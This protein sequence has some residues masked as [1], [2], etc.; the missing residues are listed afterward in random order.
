MNELLDTVELVVDARKARL[1]ALDD[2][3][4]K[5]DDMTRHLN[6]VNNALQGLAQPVVF[7]KTAADIKAMI[8]QA[9]R[10]GRF[11]KGKAA[12]LNPKEMAAALGYDP[13]AVESFITQSMLGGRSKV[14]Q[15]FRRQMREMVGAAGDFRSFGKAEKFFE[16]FTKRYDPKQNPVSA[17]QM[18]FGGGGMPGTATVKGGPVTAGGGP[19]SLVIPP[20]Q[21]V[22]T[23]G[24]G[25]IS[26]TI[27]AA[28]AAGVGGV[29]GSSVGGAAVP[30][31]AV[32]TAAK[33]IV[34]QIRTELPSGKQRVRSVAGSTTTDTTGGKQVVT[35]DLKAAARERL[36]TKL[37]KVEAEYNKAV[38]SVLKQP[39]KQRNFS[40]L[41]TAGKKAGEQAKALGDSKDFA[42]LDARSRSSIT[43]KF[44]KGILKQANT[45]ADSL[46]AEMT[47]SFER[48][49]K[50]RQ[51]LAKA[52]AD[53]DKQ[54][55]Q[56]IRREVKEEQKRQLEIGRMGQA[57]DAAGE[58]IAEAKRKTATFEKQSADDAVRIATTHQQ[59]QAV[60]DD[61]RKR[62]A[63][64]SERTIQEVGR[65]GKLTNQREV[66][67]VLDQ[68]G[69]RTTTRASFSKT[70]ARLSQAET[71]T[72]SGGESWLARGAKGFSPGGFAKNILSIG[73]WSAAVAA[74]YAPIQLVTYSLGQ[75]VEIGL[76]TARLSQTF[77]GVGG[78][79]TELRDDVLA[80]ASATGQQSK[81]AMESAVAW[82]RLG[83]SRQQ[84]AEAVRV[85]L[86]AANVAEMTAAES[87]EHLAAVTSGYRLQVSELEGVLGMLNQT[88]NTARVRNAD[89]LIGLSNVA[90]VGREAGFSLAELNGIIGASVELSGQTGSRMSNALKNVITRLGRDDV[91]SYLER[92]TGVETLRPDGS[93]KS[94]SEVVREL[95]VAYT[96]L[97]EAERTNLAGRVAGAHQANRFAGIM[98]SYLRAQQLAIDSQLNLNSAQQE[99][100]KIIATLKSQLAGLAAEWNRS[101]VKMDLEKFFADAVRAAKNLLREL[102]QLKGVRGRGGLSPVGQFEIG[103]QEAADFMGKN[104]G[105]LQQLAFVAQNNFQRRGR[106][107]FEHLF[108][109]LVPSSGL[110]WRGGRMAE[111]L[112]RRNE[113]PFE[114]GEEKFR[115]EIQQ[116]QMRAAGKKKDAELYDTIGAVMRE[117]R[118]DW[119]KN[120]AGIAAKRMG[121]KGKEFLN[122]DPARQQ[123]LLQAA[124]ARALQESQQAH[125][126]ALTQTQQRQKQAEERV[127][128][129]DNIIANKSGT[130]QAEQ[131]VG[132]RAGLVQQMQELKAVNDEVWGK[133]ND[134]LQDSLSGDLQ[135]KD[136]RQDQLDDVLKSIADWWEQISAPTAVGRLQQKANMLTE[137][138]SFMESFQASPEFDKRFTTEAQQKE[139]IEKLKQLK[140]QRDAA[141]DPV[142][143]NYV[144]GLDVQQKNREQV[145]RSIVPYNYGTDETE[146]IMRQLAELE[147]RK[148][149]L[150]RFQGPM[151]N[152]QQADLDNVEILLEQ[153]KKDLLDRQYEV[154]RDIN[155]LIADRNK[156][157]QK[158]FFGAGP[159]EMLRKL[160]AFR[161]AFD[162]KGNKR[163]M[164]MGQFY[165][166]NPN[167]RSDFNQF[168]PQ[169]DPDLMGLQRE[170]SRYGKNNPMPVTIVSPGGPVNTGTTQPQPNVPRTGTNG[171]AQADPMLTTLTA[172]KETMD[173]FTG[174]VDRAGVALDRLAERIGNVSAKVDTLSLPHNPQA[175]GNRSGTDMR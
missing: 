100:A 128:E 126:E 33:G 4:R 87:T 103:Q 71:A 54:S 142:T 25:P 144:A 94:R 73:A 45:T 167:M 11:G 36:L 69:R 166:M 41:I 127:A 152:K 44:S 38:A 165:A 119:Q 173:K 112:A 51:E 145:T 170:Q 13:K 43:G 138:V 47:A 18:L 118:P 77:R 79:V 90:A 101:V 21:I 153:R 161:L 91:Q 8:D 130:P 24:P 102:N 62:G 162:D 135:V 96:K 56:R 65:G 116:A 140:A 83:L 88:S 143:R 61:L 3:N 93:E 80:L 172:A 125:E 113:T 30:P 67:A 122:A 147:R 19:I 27:P 149:E 59:A 14:Q 129:L 17:L 50:L 68:D 158:S 75:M 123:E 74:L 1:T 12:S 132:E 35:Q 58:K 81:D 111:L 137:Q 154:Q 66:T 16:Q 108:N 121:D 92:K 26:L 72:P 146:K 124:K 169:F 134:D 46:E 164:S 31:S 139:Q 85:S 106:S 148:A 63:K 23:L 10:M 163:D 109:R 22:A 78:T 98:D 120:A 32:A 29:A 156:E 105:R 84:D 151:S 60:I 104:P 171:G 155:Q 114:R 34:T 6:A 174:S 89:L 97:N 2:A 110:M 39:P 20:S 141:T 9:Q 157:L 99:N 133:Y 117:G 159:E 160:A 57:R 5:L 52:K 64:I 115:N 131:A 175:G 48:V 86:M 168:N 82:S 150:T 136:L 55:E 53:H 40:D 42:A 49:G 28:Q 15:A 107:Q 7:K 37:E 95:F 70:R 76:Q